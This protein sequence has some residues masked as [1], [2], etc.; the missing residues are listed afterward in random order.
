[1]LIS[2]ETKQREL[3]PTYKFMNDVFVWSC[4]EC[5]RMFFIPTGEAHLHNVPAPV[6]REFTCHTC[7]SAGWIVK[8]SSAQEDS[9]HL[10]VQAEF[11]SR[12]TQ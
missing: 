3:W 5:A 12:T 1:M 11:G 9:E 4:S 8:P 7:A 6:T 2:S 10:V